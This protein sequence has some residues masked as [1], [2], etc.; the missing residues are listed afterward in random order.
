MINSLGHTHIDIL[1]IDV[2]G[3]EFQALSS[4]LKPYLPSRSNSTTPAPLPIGQLQIELHTWDKTFP[5][6]LSWWEDLEK[7]G[8]RPFMKEA[9]LVYSNYNRHRDQDLTEVSCETCRSVAIY[10]H[11]VLMKIVNPHTSIHSSISGAQIY[12]C[13]THLRWK[14]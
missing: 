9:N 2:E 1:K 12:L 7:A 11:L 6:I 5:E 8:L 14:L 4:F 3:W 13:R 10:F